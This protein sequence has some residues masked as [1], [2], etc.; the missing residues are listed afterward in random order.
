MGSKRAHIAK[1][2]GQLRRNDVPKLKLPYARCVDNRGPLVDP[3]PCGR[4]GG[5]L[6]FLV[7]Q[8]DGL[9]ALCKSRDQVVE[10]ARLADAALPDHGSA[11]ALY[12]GAQEVHS[13]AFYGAEHHG[14]VP[15]LR[16][17]TDEGLKPL[18]IDQVAFIDA[19]GRFD[20][21]LLGRRQDPIDQIRFDAGFRGAGHDEDLIDVRCDDM[22]AI[23]ARAAQFRRSRFDAYN[24]AL[25]SGLRFDT[26][27]IAGHDD[28]PLGGREIL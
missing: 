8:A 16:V 26:D 23:L 27:P 3:K 17:A 28:M 19:Y 14:L 7:V 11:F 9:D 20:L 15:H 6:A 13:P 4:R 2:S 10:D 25:V 1:K 22:P 21:I 12:P 24:P 5:V 18:G